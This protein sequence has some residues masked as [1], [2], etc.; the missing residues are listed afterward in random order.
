MSKIIIDDRSSVGVIAAIDSVRRVVANGRIS[1]N[2]K[3][4]RYVS[5]FHSTEGV[6]YVLSRLNKQSDSF[7]IIDNLEQT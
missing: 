6:V 2:N 5:C 7:I 1:N 3:Q 4:Y